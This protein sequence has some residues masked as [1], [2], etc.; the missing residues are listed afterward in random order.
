MKIEIAPSILS[1]DFGK[2]NAEIA[3]VEPYVDRLHIDVMDGHFVSNISFGAPVMKWIRSDLQRDVHLMIEHPWR[4]F[5]DFVEAGADTIIV[6]AEACESSGTEFDLPNVLKKLKEMGVKAAFS[7]KPGT[8]VESVKSCL[9]L[10]DQVLVMTVEPGFGGQ[11][12]RED[13]VGKIRELREDGFDGVIGVDGGIND[14]TARI[15]I[16][17]G[18]NLLIAGNYIFGAEDRVQRIKNLQ[19]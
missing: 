10:V 13:M 11:E 18:A 5:E 7:I 14:K 4:Y 17:A 19:Q 3:E 16:A 6:H 2:L 8:S 12:F 15:C 1:A 9:C